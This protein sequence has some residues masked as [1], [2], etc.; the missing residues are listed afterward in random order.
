MLTMRKLTLLR[1]CP[2]VL[3][4]GLLVASSSARA[5]AVITGGTE[6]ATN[7]SFTANF[8]Q[9]YDFVS[10]IDQSLTALGFWD[11]GA[12][13]LPSA[14]R[15]GLWDTNTQNLLASATIDDS[16]PLNLGLTINGGNYRFEILPLPVALLAGTT[17]TLSFQVGPGGIN[18]T[19]S[20][21]LSFP[22]VSTGSTAT[23]PNRIRFR[24]STSFD[25]PTNT[26]SADSL[27]RANVNAIIGPST[28]VPEP[29]T[30]AM[31]GFG[32][33]ALVVLRRRR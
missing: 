24:S 27:L 31:L 20:L 30:V 22:T 7:T 16:D 28:V 9:G 12:N 32:M 3:L 6:I 11:Q 13:G 10:T 1:T 15:V 19:D 26:L 29:S 14:F 5:D 25:F 18:S 23:V 17:Y 33:I 4:A 8:M 21:F 2:L